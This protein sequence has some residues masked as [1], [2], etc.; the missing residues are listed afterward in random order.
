MQTHFGEP[1]QKRHHFHLMWGVMGWHSKGK[2]SH[3]SRQQLKI[4]RSCCWYPSCCVYCKRFL[5]EKC[6]WIVSC[7][8][9]FALKSTT[10][11]IQVVPWSRHLDSHYRDIGL[12]PILAH[13]VSVVGTDTGTCVSAT[14]SVFTTQSSFHERSIHICHRRHRQAHMSRCVEGLSLNP[15]S[16]L[17]FITWNYAVT[18][19]HSSLP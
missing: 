4:V 8:N 1:L 19:W 13:L 16:Y 10:S 2:W 11:W 15:L 9:K 6:A 5:L 7:S 14:D 12:N 18:C 3:K 17:L